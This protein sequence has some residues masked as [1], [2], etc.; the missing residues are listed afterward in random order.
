ME[1]TFWG[2]KNNWKMLTCNMLDLE[3]LG[4]WS[5]MSKNFPDTGVDMAVFKDMFRLYLWTTNIL[6]Y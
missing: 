3:W 5:N 4:S 2:I 6:C 1:Y